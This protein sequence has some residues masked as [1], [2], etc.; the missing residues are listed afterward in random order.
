MDENRRLALARE[1]AKSFAFLFVMLILAFLVMQGTDATDTSQA[2]TNWLIIGVALAGATIL[3]WLYALVLER[4]ERA[5]RP[6]GQRNR[7][8]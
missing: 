6:H 1:A 2:Q 3:S 5:A 8:V 7:R 4:D